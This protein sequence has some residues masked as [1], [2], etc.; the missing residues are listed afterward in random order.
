MME[1][2]FFASR[3][4]ECSQYTPVSDFPFCA[5]ILYFPHFSW[6]FA[7]QTGARCALSS[8]FALLFEGP[9]PRSLPSIPQPLVGL[10]E[11]GGAPQAEHSSPIQ[12]LVLSQP[13]LLL[14]PAACGIF[15]LVSDTCR[16]LSSPL[17]FYLGLV[18]S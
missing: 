2:G 16:A 4:R 14:R 11:Y 8:S 6:S 5:C 18:W 3:S 12:T 9:M 17:F 1:V 10:L 15:R 13:E 7:L